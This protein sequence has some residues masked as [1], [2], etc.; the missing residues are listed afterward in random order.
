MPQGKARLLGQIAFAQAGQKKRL[1]A[2]KTALST[3]KLD[4]K[5]PRAYLALVAAT[6]LVSANKILAEL[7]KRG[8]GI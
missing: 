7:N 6:G 4:F 3:I 8:R 5:Q 2:A 1:A